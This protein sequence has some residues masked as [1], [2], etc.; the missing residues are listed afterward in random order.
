MQHL[1]RRLESRIVKIF[2]RG[3]M[4]CIT[5]CAARNEVLS[6]HSISR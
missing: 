1:E 5:L 6:S 4:E 3:G 2:E